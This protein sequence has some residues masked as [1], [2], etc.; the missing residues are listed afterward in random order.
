M[1]DVHIHVLAMQHY[2]HIPAG[3]SVLSSTLR[4]QGRVLRFLLSNSLW[5]ELLAEIYLQLVWCVW[6][7]SVLCFAHTHLCVPGPAGQVGEWNIYIIYIS[8]HSEQLI[9]FSTVLLLLLLCSS[10]QKH[11]WVCS[12]AYPKGQLLIFSWEPVA[13]PWSL[14]TTA[15][16]FTN[17]FSL[18]RPFHCASPFLCG[19]K[20][21]RGAC[22]W[23][24]G[25]AG[26]VGICEPPQLAV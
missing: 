9:E 6:Q 22:V 13:P 15:N 18:S 16:V 7:I 14:G 5:G 3:T 17:S 24:A 19:T 11:T 23:S 10:L 20:A 1:C 25:A 4:S 2:S 26:A 21:L 12:V 8:V